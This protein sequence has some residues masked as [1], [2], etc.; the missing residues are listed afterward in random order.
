MMNNNL[1]LTMVTAA[2]H[3]VGGTVL[4]TFIDEQGKTII[5][6]TDANGLVDFYGKLAE[7]LKVAKDLQKIYVTNYVVESLTK[8]YY[9]K[10][11]QYGKTFSGTKF[12]VSDMNVLRNFSLTLDSVVNLVQ[13]T[14]INEDLYVSTDNYSYDKTVEQMIIYRSNAANNSVLANNKIVFDER[15]IAKPTTT[16]VNE[17]VITVIQTTK[18]TKEQKEI[19]IDCKSTERKEEKPSI[20]IKLDSDIDVSRVAD[21]Y[22][23]DIFYTEEDIQSLL[24]MGDEYVSSIPQSEEVKIIIDT[25]KAKPQQPKE[26]IVIQIKEEK[27]VKPQEIKVQQE[28]KPQDEDMMMLL[29]KEMRELKAMV[30]KLTTDVEELKKDNKAKDKT[31]EKLTKE[32]NK[33]DDVDTALED[34]S[35]VPKE[36]IESNTNVDD[37]S[38]TNHV[39]QSIIHTEQPSSKPQKKR[40]S[41]G[42]VNFDALNKRFG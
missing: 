36:S 22:G 10:W 15:V 40:R 6:R 29:L 20:T 17:D 28:A 4:Y 24:M 8:A 2:S 5:K 19:I 13:F 12:S 30:S 39:Q 35:S 7:A 41:N 11:L 14:V 25:P 21:E 9:K 18:E 37:K 3:K 38:N 31:I 34:N 1:K 32:L 33:T 26:E 42:G 16:Y 27:E 23:D